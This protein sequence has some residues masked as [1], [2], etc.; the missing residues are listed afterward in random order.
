M[1]RQIRRL[2]LALVVLYAV[3][4]AQVNLTQLARAE[5]Y[6]EDPG[7]TR[8]VVRD[9]ARERG[10]IV[11]ADGVVVAA[12]QP[13]DD[14]YELLRTYPEGELYAHVTG[15]FSF[16][17]GMDGVERQYNDELA[18]RTAA[19][20]VT[21][22]GNLFTSDVDT[23]DVTLTLLD[24]VQRVAR[25]QLGERDG[26]V[27]ALDP[28]TGAVLA[29]WSYPSY[30]PN[31]LASHDFALARQARTDLLADERDPLLA[32]TYRERYFPGS[33]F[34][35]VTAATGVE[36]GAVTIEA[37]V[38]PV[39]DAYVPPLTTRPIQNFG[40][41]A[42]GGAL[43]DIL[44]VSCNTA[45]AQMGVELGAEVMV[46]G[47]EAFGFN[48]EPPVD[49]PGA[50][51]SNF[52]P[53]G[54]FDRNT[55]AL[56]Q[57]AI[58]QNDV[59]ATPLQMAL[60]AAGIANRGA[61]MVPRVVAS[62]VDERG[63]T[64]YAFRPTLWRQAVSVATADTV[65]DALVGVVATGTATRMQVEGVTVG[66]KTGTAQLGTDPPS[67]HAWV[68]GFAPAEN[69]RVAV[70]VLVK[71]QPGVSEV[72]GGRVAAPIARAVIE[73]VLATPDPLGPGS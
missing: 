14:R 42:C 21:S 8:E 53:V 51:A 11:T 10:G 36:S 7:N 60:V 72:T 32:H 29:L 24:T 12:S 19:Q 50:A 61:V 69:P 65:R 33:T 6:N 46:A 67:S 25:D 1:N 5:R 17:F 41:S 35:V 57:S 30:D 38:Y 44:R 70:A 45:F 31:V 63:R 47:A 16:E 43:L 27:V 59:S 28:R 73:A 13:A 64:L 56:A 37:P 20:R 54:F 18:G 4:F 62:V 68:I 22:L 23:A 66:G 2:G 26:A 52:P 55:P 9:Y 15:F 48:E 34:K 39:S 58:G 49:L 3:L 71:A 40:G